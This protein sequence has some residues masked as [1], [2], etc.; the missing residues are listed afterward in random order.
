[1]GHTSLKYLQQNQFDLVKIDG[2]LVKAALEN[3]RS[4][5]IIS[6]IIYLSSSLHFDVVAE[7]VETKKE[8]EMLENLGC[9]IY[10]GY[11][12]GKAV[13]L[14]EFVKVHSRG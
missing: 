2:A 10:Q 3:Q 1:M 12:Y 6:S 8:H 9:A 11:L 7:F 5:D 14:E 4:R 13:S